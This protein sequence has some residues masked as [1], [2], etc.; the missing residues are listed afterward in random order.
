MK[1]SLQRRAAG[2][3]EGESGEMGTET[4]QKFVN[5]NMG[6]G[7]MNM[8]SGLTISILSRLN[9]CSQDCV[10]QSDFEGFLDHPMWSCDGSP[11]LHPGGGNWLGVAV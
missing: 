2:Q 4:D 8:S 1:R 9:N 3:W 6:S 10:S 7:S 5:M 11:N